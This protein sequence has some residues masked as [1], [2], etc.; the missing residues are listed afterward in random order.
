MKSAVWGADYGWVVEDLDGRLASDPENLVVFMAEAA[1]VVV[2]AAWLE[3]NPGT[4]FGGLWGGSTLAEWRGR[5]IYKALVA[6]RA[7]VAAARGVKYLQ[8]DASAASEPILRRLG[9]TAIT[10]TT[11][12][13]WTQ[14]AGGDS[15][16]VR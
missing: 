6:A 2:S 14:P 4:D 12:Y 7:R 10:T 8:V 13:V 1:G 11:P 9:F 16:A 3:I 5:G 15:G